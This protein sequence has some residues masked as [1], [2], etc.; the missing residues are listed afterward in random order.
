MYKQSIK[1]NQDF[2]IIE[3]IEYDKDGNI[4]EIERYD[5]DGYA[6]YHYYKFSP[7][8]PYTGEFWYKWEYDNIGRCIR[9][10]ESNGYWATHEYDD[11]GNEIYLLASNGFFRKK[12]Y[13]NLNRLIKVEDDVGTAS[14]DYHGDTDKTKTIYMSNGNIIHYDIN[15]NK[16]ISRIP[17]EHV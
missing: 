10:E 11:M 15:R 4:L 5:D 9:E 17:N 2:N 8:E 3:Y 16:T 7:W 1:Y 12:T 13:D 6:I 14:K